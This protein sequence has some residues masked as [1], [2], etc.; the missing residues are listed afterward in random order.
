M[1]GRHAIARMTSGVTPVGAWII[2]EVKRL[3][4]QHEAAT[5]RVRDGQ[6]TAS[7]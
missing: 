6:A 5:M 1:A 2:A 3:G 4:G 7:L